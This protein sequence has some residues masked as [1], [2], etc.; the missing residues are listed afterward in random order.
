VVVQ[1]DGLVR[2]PVLVVGTLEELQQ[3]IGDPPLSIVGGRRGFEA[4]AGVAARGL[5]QRIARRLAGQE[6]HERAVH[7]APDEVDRPG[8]VDR[9]VGDRA[10]RR[11]QREASRKCAESVEHA[12]LRGGEQA[13]AP[14]ERGLQH[15]VPLVFGAASNP[16]QAKALAEVRNESR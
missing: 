10:G 5:E 14:V 12:L 11:L 3:R 7:E 4:R 15:A 13:V 6:G 2:R 8:D 16:Q 1:P 9:R